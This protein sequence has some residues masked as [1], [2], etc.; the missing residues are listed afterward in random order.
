MTNA[1]AQVVVGLP[2]EGPFDYFIPE[3]LREKI[4]IGSRVGVFFGK[5]KLTGF[6]I[7]LK[8]K[9]LY[10]KLK[11]ILSL[12][13]SHP[14]LSPEILKFT[15]ALAEYYGCSW[16]E[17]LEICLP[18]ALRK[19]RELNLSLLESENPKLLETPKH[20]LLFDPGGQKRWPFLIDAIKAVR[21]QNQGVILLTAEAI[22]IDFIHEQLR[23]VFSEDMA[24]FGK[25]MTAKKELEEWQKIKEGKVQIVLGTRSAIFSPVKNL[26][27]IVILEE[28]QQA[29]KQEQSPHY[30]ARDAAM[31]RSTIAGCRVIYASTA[32]SAEIWSLA[33]KKNMDM[34]S[35]E[36]ETRVSAQLVDMS[37]Y[38]WKKS[39]LLSIPLRSAIQKV[40]GAGGKAVLFL[41]RR[42]FSTRTRCN[43]CGFTLK[44]KRCD[45]N[46]IYLFHQKKMVCRH[47]SYSTVPLNL[48]PQCRGSYLKYSGMGSEKLESEV[49]RQFPQ[50]KVARF[51]KESHSFDNNFQVLIGTQALLHL[52]GK[53]SAEFIGVLQADAELNRNDFR[54]A[55]RTFS[56]LCGLRS[57]CKE[58][59]FI[60]S[61]I[62]D[63]YCLKAFVKNDPQKFYREELKFRRQ[64]G[65]PPFRTLIAISLRGK[66]EDAVFAHAQELC[67]KISS[68]PKAKTI[69]ILDPQ[70]DIVP[71]LRDKF[72][73][74]IMLKGKSKTTM[75]SV[76]QK[77]LKSFGKKSGMIVSVNVDP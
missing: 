14:S 30:H 45:S 71:K 10:P 51:D 50:A 56:L 18:A 23:S 29:F 28:D 46:L 26:G 59:M 12:L 44:C 2:I 31:L 7:G 36:D 42:G 39:S 19:G 53:L 58:K 74:T 70:S 35:M 68:D 49:A 13:D 47:C 55:Q 43:Q 66:K 22:Y 52:R 5:R 4:A 60:Q 15:K 25:T 54:S 69:E 24:V 1:I 16:G 34:I 3:S 9:S 65:L 57:M 62:I 8:P 76:I 40:L 75:L 20:I 48:C 72:R 73:F 32:P 38:Q 21:A 17:A 6:T 11:P 67:Q 41:N 64:A 77:T 27:L 33:S 63:N 37:N 61:S